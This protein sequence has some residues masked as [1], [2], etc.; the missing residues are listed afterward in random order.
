MKVLS[1]DT[2]EFPGGFSF[3]KRHAFMKDIFAGKVQPYLFHMSWT[4]NKDNKQKFFK[5]IGGWYLEDKCAGSTASEI[6]E[7]N[8]GDVDAVAPLQ[9]P[10]CLAE[11]SLTCFYKDKPSVKPCNDSPVLDKGAKSFW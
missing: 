2:E 7:K 4:A 10:C 1:R 6:L 11:P 9:K 8:V 5:Q 3:H